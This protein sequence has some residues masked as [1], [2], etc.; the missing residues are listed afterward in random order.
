V[1]DLSVRIGPF[2]LKN[3]IIAASGCFGY[4]VEYADVVDL[5]LL[6]GVAVK[7]L[8]LAE[9]EGHPPERIVE[10]PAGMLNAIGLQGI[11]VHRFIREK[12]PVLR[13]HRAT[14]VVNI[15]GS[16]LEEY[17]E[18]AR[19]LS[20][21]EGVAALELNISCPNIKEGGITFGCSLT[22]TFDVVSAVKKVTPLPVIPKLTPNVTDVA[23][24]ARASE[25]AG[26]DAV[27][28]VNTFLAMAI[29]IETRRPKLSN[30][31]GGLSGPAIRPIAVRMVYECSRTVKIPVIGMGGIASAR[32]VLEFLIAGASAVQVGTANFVDPFIWTKLLDGLRD[33]MERHRVARLADLTGTVD[34][35]SREKEWISS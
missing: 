15:C 11:G 20:D 34:T 10:T 1:T 6:G 7:G 14:V 28:L 29:D 27:A 18:L 23:S 25:D 24:F 21:A 32:D 31:V 5:S 22:G 16:T 19:I 26:A 35:T 8:F 17:V 30:I 12:L 13:D 9:R 4:G 2:T 3:P 33:Y